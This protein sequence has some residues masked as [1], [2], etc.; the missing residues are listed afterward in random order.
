VNE[1][2]LRT[3]LL[4]GDLGFGQALARALGDGFEVETREAGELA[5][6]EDG[7][8]PWE[9]V[10]LDFEGARNSVEEELELVQRVHRIE[11]PP[12]VVVIRASREPGLTARLIESGVYDTLA[13][14]P[15]MTELRLV[16]R[17]AAKFHRAEQELHQLRSKL[18]GPKGLDKLVGNS[19][20]M[21][22]VFAM[23][24]RVAPCDVNVLVTGETGTGKELLARAI[25]NLSARAGGP[26]VAF[27]CANLPESLVED[28]LFGHEKG[29]F[30]G[31]LTMRRG[32][33]ET[34]NC[35]TVF[36]DEI[37]DLGLGLQPKLLRVIQERVFSRLGSNALVSANVRLVCATHQNLEE[38]VQQGRFREDLYYRLNVVQLSLPPLRERRED[39][40]LLAYHF[41]R[42]FAQQY[43][44]KV[45]RFAPRVLLAL[46]DHT[47][48]GNVRELENVIQRAVVLADGPTIQMWHL[49]ASF[50]T[51]LQPSQVLRSYEEEVRDFKRRLILRVLRECGWQKAAT[52]RTLGLARPY[53]HRLITQLQIREEGEEPQVEPLDQLTPTGPSGRPS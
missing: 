38:M 2:K 17:R 13:G 36:L 27:S 5:A 28:E 30:T 15:D 31:A 8:A 14:P 10:V 41:L 4:T 24:R 33:F 9:V 18:T 52:A 35:G 23:A 3:L 1:I 6:P 46:E 7:K 47:W 19:E 37:G 44:K 25:H 12:P 34:A 26:F 29:A 32:C 43:G 40:P 51:S 49:P 48:P 45:S 42:Q 50:H 39:I 53:L 20:R 16:L 11:L 22:Q 21:Q